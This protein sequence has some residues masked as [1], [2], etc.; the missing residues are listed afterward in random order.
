MADKEEEE[1]VV[2][3]GLRERCPTSPAGEQTE[4]QSPRCLSEVCDGTL[5]GTKMSNHVSLMTNE[6]LSACA[7]T[8]WKEIA[9][10]LK[11]PQ[12]TLE[13]SVDPS[14]WGEIFLPLAERSANAQS[15][16]WTAHLMPGLK[17]ECHLEDREVAEYGKVKAAILRVDAISMEVQ[18]L[19]FRRFQYKEVDG[20]REACSRLWFLCHR[21]LKPERHT[22]EQ[23]LELLILEQFM[24]ILPPEIESW[25]KDGC[26]ENCAQAVT[27]AED[28]LLRQ[29]EAESPK[30]QVRRA[31]APYQSHVI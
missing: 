3:L 18:R 28:F 13:T 7:E 24:T 6:E 12:S 9:G 5:E 2:P 19:H 30:Q 27:L 10:S 21:W 8:Q 20:P 31:F 25:V 15:G 4:E 1:V 14:C 23:I 22:R 16:K 29:Q 17:D 26:P 11:K